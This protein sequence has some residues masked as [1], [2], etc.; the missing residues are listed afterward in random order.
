MHGLFISLSFRINSFPFHSCY[1]MFILQVFKNKLSLIHRRML[2]S[3][4]W[5][6]LPIIQL[7]WSRAI[8]R[9]KLLIQLNQLKP[10]AET[11]TLAHT[12]AT[13]HLPHSTTTN[14]NTA[15]TLTQW[16][17]IIELNINTH[18]HTHSTG[19]S[20]DTTADPGF[21]LG[22][23]QIQ[24]FSFLLSCLD[25]YTCNMLPNFVINDWGF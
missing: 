20:A 17:T 2:C 21:C 10:T 23:G 22:E 9:F 7:K 8:R 25:I 14:Q 4:L 1:F 16:L 3:M 5:T 6:I 11:F 19:Y 15:F 12:Q 18:T 13:V 24:I